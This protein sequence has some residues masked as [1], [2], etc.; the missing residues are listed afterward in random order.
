MQYAVCGQKVG[1]QNA[2]RAVPLLKVGRLEPSHWDT[3]RR[4]CTGEQQQHLAGCRGNNQQLAHWWWNTS[5]T[6]VGLCD[7]QAVRGGKPVV[8]VHCVITTNLLYRPTTCIFLLPT[9]IVIIFIILIIT[10]TSSS[11]SSSFLLLQSVCVRRVAATASLA[12][13][14]SETGYFYISNFCTRHISFWPTLVV[15]SRG[16]G[17]AWVRREYGDC[18]RLQCMLCRLAVC[19]C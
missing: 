17:T 16:V 3:F 10:T 7:W 5:L 2:L 6:G 19:I 8:T 12:N 1:R 9:T 15:K 4:H 11:S 14:H 18:R 13:R